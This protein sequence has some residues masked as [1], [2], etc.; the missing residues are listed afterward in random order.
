MIVDSCRD[1]MSRVPVALQY[2]ADLR[3]DV[4]KAVKLVVVSHW[5]DDHI[6]GA[7]D[8]IRA[9]ESTSV[10][11]S[12]AVR[13]EEFLAMVGAS[14]RAMMQSSGVSEMRS[15]LALIQERNLPGTRAGSAGP[16]LAKANVN[17]W[18]NGS[19]RK[20]YDAEVQALSPSDGACM[21]SW[22]AIADG[23]PEL[24]V[25]KRR[26][27]VLSP[28]Q[29]AVVV[30]VSA[31]RVRALLGA[32]LEESA[33]PTMGWRAILASPTRPTDRAAIFKVP[34][35]GSINAD[36]PQVWERMLTP[37]PHALLAPFASGGKFLP[38]RSDVTRLL[39]RTPNVHCTAPSGGFSPP[40]R[41]SAVE[42]MARQ[43]T[44]GTRKAIRGPMG[45]VRIR[46]RISGGS[47]SVHY[48]G[49]AFRATL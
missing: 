36:S 23:L 16:V 4:P 43:V 2:L 33:S 12:S 27:V 21:L 9:A 47:L 3:V 22:R 25:P 17:L 32:D 48:C 6:Q 31:G 45:H 39:S 40:F 44:G 29:V 5:H 26:A 14:P 15:I 24:G 49:S 8:V 1:R 37:E 13:H 18:P 46:G 28:N 34:H 19:A 42:K 10:A 35:H 30:W 11:C 20:L 38:T 7:A 41:S